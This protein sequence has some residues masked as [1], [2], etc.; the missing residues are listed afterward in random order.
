MP[1]PKRHRV[2][3][4]GSVVLTLLGLGCAMAGGSVQYAEAVRLGSSVAGIGLLL[5]GVL[6]LLAAAAAG[7]IAGVGPLVAGALCGLIGLVAM[8]SQQTLWELTDLF[9]IRLLQI[10]ALAY[11]SVLCPVAA[12]LLVG[13]GLSGRWNRD[14]AAA[15][16]GASGPGAPGPI[17]EL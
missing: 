3:V 14:P 13:A 17:V 8:F 5:L 4:I 6:L 16:G 9:G 7:R 11:A 12:A 15:Q 2:S 10:G 1:W